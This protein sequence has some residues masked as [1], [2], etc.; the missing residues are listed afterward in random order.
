V[1][2]TGGPTGV[3]V[4]DSLV[5]SECANRGPHLVDKETRLF[6]RG[7]V[8]ALVEGAVVTDVGVAGSQ[9]RSLMR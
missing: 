5:R 3:R 2:R 7:E 6:E 9:Q 1:F 8:A 4:S